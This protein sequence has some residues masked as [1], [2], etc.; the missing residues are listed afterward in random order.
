MKRLFRGATVLLALW[1]TP[2]PAEA[3]ETGHAACAA[4][5]ARMPAAI[6]GF[7]LLGRQEYATREHGFAAQYEDRDGARLSVFHYTGGLSEQALSTPDVP[8]MM[9]QEMGRIVAYLREQGLT[10]TTPFQIGLSA[11]G[12]PSAAQQGFREVFGLRD[13]TVLGVARGCIVKLRYTGAPLE[14]PT[15]RRLWETATQEK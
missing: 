3:P 10:P 9:R 15:L 14:T 13:M 4:M 7:K 1:V 12:N 8:A 11:T 2:A 5:H 6:V